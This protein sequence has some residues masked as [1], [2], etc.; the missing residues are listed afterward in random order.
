M[1][2]KFEKGRIH[3]FI[4]TSPIG[5]KNAEKVIEKYVDSN[6]LTVLFVDSN[7]K[8][9]LLSL[10]SNIE[11][12]EN[13]ISDSKYRTAINR[14]KVLEIIKRKY[15]RYK[16]CY[17]YIMD[18]DAITN[19]IVNYFHCE[20]KRINIIED[21]L[22]NYIKSYP[23][24]TSFIHQILKVLYY[25]LFGIRTKMFFGTCT[26][27]ET[28]QISYQYL[29]YPELSLH[30]QKT[31]P[32]EFDSISYTPDE[33]IILILGQTMEIDNEIVYREVLRNLIE[34]IKV[35][36]Q[37][38][39]NQFIYKP[40]RWEKWNISDILFEFSLVKLYDTNPVE[41]IVAEIRPKYIYSFGSS[42]LINISMAIEKT[43]RK[44]VEIYA[45]PYLEKE[46]YEQIIPL[47]KKANI[48]VI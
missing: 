18:Y 40:H 2:N 26:G 17:F 7:Y 6:E 27:I 3:I 37:G 23:S 13:F 29:R 22:V 44:E 46:V 14:K 11:N 45:Y 10:W 28:Q 48:I 32:I 16:L 15:S 8:P 43:R 30:P 1:K 25:S 41:T 4:L 21:G 42:A 9:T 12:I 20:D 36:H 47:F 24:S 33:N 34:L 38:N 35:K 39:V 31:L 5:I 19:Y